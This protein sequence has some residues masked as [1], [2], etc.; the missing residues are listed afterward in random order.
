MRI[1]RRWIVIAILG[2]LYLGHCA[3]P[4]DAIEG[5]PGGDIEQAIRTGQY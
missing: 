2:V 3:G 4:Q 5:L 1:R